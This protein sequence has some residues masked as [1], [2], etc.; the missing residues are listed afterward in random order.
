MLWNSSTEKVAANACDLR[1]PF[2]HGV[3]KQS[4]GQQQQQA[5]GGHEKRGACSS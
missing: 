4:A 5:Q 2:M 1:L 3:S